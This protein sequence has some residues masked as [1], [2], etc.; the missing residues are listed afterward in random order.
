MVDELTNAFEVE[1]QIVNE[2]VAQFHMAG[3]HPVTR[4][5]HSGRTITR[6]EPLA[7]GEAVMTIVPALR[8]KRQ[9]DRSF[10]ALVVLRVDPA[11]DRY[12]CTPDY[13]YP[14]LRSRCKTCEV[15]LPL[16]ELFNSALA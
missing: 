8:T 13:G 10:P 4:L 6:E 16:I 5:T 3:V 9:N 2:I 15:P 1:R 12:Q 11:Y 7:G 14:L